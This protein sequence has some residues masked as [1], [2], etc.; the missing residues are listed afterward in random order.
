MT[1]F[2]ERAEQLMNDNSLGPQHGSAFDFTLTFEES[3][4]SL[5]PAA[6]LLLVTPIHVVY[7]R[8]LKVT[9]PEDPL[10]WGKMVSP[11]LQLL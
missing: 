1:A 8:K 9:S 11:T 5:A 6:I 2:Q 4:F 3:F 10:M 7:Y